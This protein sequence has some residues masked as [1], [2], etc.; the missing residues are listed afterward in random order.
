[1][2]AAA[3]VICGALA[4]FWLTA[5]A[6]LGPALLPKLKFAQFLSA[7]TICYSAAMAATAF[8]SGWILDSMHNDYH[9]IYLMACTAMT[10]SLVVSVV[11][12]KKFLAYGGPRGYVAPE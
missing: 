8:L 12:Y 6:S 7:M 10:A 2:F 11:V 9:Y 5:T 3:H 4:G 1:T